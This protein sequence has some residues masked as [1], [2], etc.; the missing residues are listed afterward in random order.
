MGTIKDLNSLQFSASDPVEMENRGTPE[1]DV[2]IASCH[3]QEEKDGKPA[4][5]SKCSVLCSNTC[6][7]SNL[8]TS[9]PP[10]ISAKCA[11]A[12][13][14]KPSEAPGQALDLNKERGQEES[15]D[16]SGNNTAD[17]NTEVDQNRKANKRSD[18]AD[19]NVEVPFQGCGEETTGT[20]RD[21]RSNLQN[22]S[23][24]AEIT[25]TNADSAVQPAGNMTENDGQIEMENEDLGAV[26]SL[27]Q[28][29]VS[30]SA[31]QDAE[32]Q[33]A[34]QVQSRSVATSPM[35]PLDNCPVFKIPDVSC[36][37]Q[38]VEKPAASPSDTPSVTV[39]PKKDV[40]MQVDITVQC[41]SVATGPM[42]PLEKTPLPTLP[43]V[44]VEATEEQSEPVREVQWDEKGMTWEVYGAS[45]DAEVLGLAIQKHLEKQIEEHGK[46]NIEIPKS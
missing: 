9:H 22:P 25:K 34:I 23:G 30:E 2:V 21:H 7:A 3:L 31:S 13:V 4:I 33:V 8:N 29:A 42:T 6:S 17:I 1:T 5:Q 20:E 14:D 39:P 41:K 12:E 24:L 10:D 27:S 43:E 44:S 38:P 35:A 40:E 15:S 11:N 36:R 16:S 46:Q 19:P 18:S 37:E 28:S 45:M 32:V 26:V